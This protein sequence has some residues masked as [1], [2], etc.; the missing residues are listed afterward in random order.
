MMQY[1]ATQSVIY[2]INLARFDLGR[3]I[4]ELTK[5]IEEINAAIVQRFSVEFTPRGSGVEYLHRDPA[6]R[7]RRRKG[8]SQI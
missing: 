6:S 8:K 1:V 4:E 7:R 3:R 2:K 5:D